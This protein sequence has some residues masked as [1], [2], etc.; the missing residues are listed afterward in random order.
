MSKK[1]IAVVNQKGGVGKTTTTI[2]LATALASIGHK[3]LLID[4]DSQG[5][6]ST[7]MGI[8]QQARDLTAY[9]LMALDTQADKVV[10]PTNIANLNSIFRKI[11]LNFQIK[12]F[13]VFPILQPNQ[14]FA[15]P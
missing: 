13:R 15:K 14:N 1:I 4:L 3:I 5:N 6:A 2:N 7:G 11:L 12:N 8:S 10:K 9:D